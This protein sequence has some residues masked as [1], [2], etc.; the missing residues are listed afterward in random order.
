MILCVDS[1]SI[2]EDMKVQSKVKI[3]D[4]LLNH[5]KYYDSEEEAVKDKYVPLDFCT[6]VRSIYS[7]EV[8]Q[9]KEK[10]GF[11]YYVNYTN[12]D[13]FIHKGLDL[14]MYLSALGLLQ[15]INYTRAF[16]ELMVKSSTIQ[17][18][19]LYNPNSGFINPIIYSHVL[20]EDSGVEVF[21]TFLKEGCE[22][23]PISDM[24]SEGNITALLDK[25]LIVKGDK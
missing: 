3:E 18:V 17:P 20:I 6:S 11:K 1:T 8:L 2:K 15:C 19:G 13:R 25:L 10:S 7:N 23:V 24:N 22:F 9:I 21:K 14:V 5:T 12:V 16:D 4:I